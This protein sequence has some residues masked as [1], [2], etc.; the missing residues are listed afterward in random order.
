ML[1]P[2]LSLPVLSSFGRIT[3]VLAYS[4]LTTLLSIIAS[5]FHHLPPTCS[6]PIVL[7]FSS[8]LSLLDLF[9]PKGR[10]EEEASLNGYAL[11]PKEQW[12]LY[13]LLYPSVF[14]V[15]SK[16][17]FNHSL[18]HSFVHSLFHSLF[19]SFIHYLTHSL[20]HYLTR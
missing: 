19:H 3:P 14:N 18:S 11:S 6:V 9:V 10:R 2:H 17:L 4:R 16:G 15:G 8:L 13:P 20:S 7:V 1:L 12:I 5:L